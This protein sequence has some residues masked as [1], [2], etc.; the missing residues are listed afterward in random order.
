MN[1]RVT[2]KTEYRYDK[3]VSASYSEAHLVPRR[4]SHQSCVSSDIVIQPQPLDYRERYDFFDNRT[5]F[6]SI[7]VPH[8]SLI[9]TATSVVEVL[10]R[11][12]Q[13]PLHTGSAWE[14]AA[15]RLHEEPDA[16]VIMARQYVLD[17]PL[18][19]VSAGLRAYAEPSFTPGRPLFEAIT[20][21]STRIHRDFDYQPGTTTI[22]TSPGEV[23]ERRRGVCQDFAHLAIGCVRAMGLPA[24]YVSGYLETRPAP[25]K[26]HLVGADATHAWLS[27]FIPDTGWVDLDPTNDQVPN[28]RYITTA[29]GRDYADVTPL[30]G[31]V[32]SG[33]SKHQL[34]VS[35]DVARV[36]T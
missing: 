3:S 30:K 15:A 21:L 7:H 29:W 24:R 25:G 4:L 19:A 26:E 5:S 28:Q 14:T 20:D 11:G 18:V 31:I 10:D 36:E 16:E 34:T 1:Y 6:F 23:L 32:F 2:H 8:T 17:S 12:A 13:L 22:A 35:V 33:A 9:V 27:V